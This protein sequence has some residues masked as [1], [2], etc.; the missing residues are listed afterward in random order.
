MAVRLEDLR[1]VSRYDGERVCGAKCPFLDGDSCRL[2]GQLYLL[3]SLDEKD[4]FIY[5]TS[6]HCDRIDCFAD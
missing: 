2:F 5:E 4:D 1:Q 6:V 3:S